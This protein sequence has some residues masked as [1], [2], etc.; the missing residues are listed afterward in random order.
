MA[1]E[2]LTEREKQVLLNLIQHYISTADPVG[3][4][5]IANKFRMGLSPATIRNTLQDLEELGLVNQPHTSAGRIP[6]DSGYRVYVNYLLKPELLTQQEKDAIKGSILKEGRGVNEI[7]GQTCKVL[8]EI[9]HQLGVSIS[10]RFDAGILKRLQLIPVAEGRI[11]IVVVVESGLA[12][13]VIIELEAT[14]P[15]SSLIEV[16][17]VLNERL[18]GLTLGEI[19][20]SISE[21]MA[22]ISGQGRLVKMIVDSKD[23]IWT[24][25]RSDEV[26]LSGAENLVA[27]PEFADIHRIS[28]LMK[29]L[30]NSSAM[31]GFFDSLEDEGLIITIGKENKLAEILNCSLVSATYKVG[32][33]SGSIGIIGP[34]RMEYNKLVSVVKYTARMIT[35]VLSRT[36]SQ[37]E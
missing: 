25:Q 14:M 35:E 29:L 19:R 4:R 18:S 30:E 22:D 8:G 21:R 5:V 26:F 36:E 33:I 23:R 16:E 11:M 10:P 28:D 7:L 1:F 27:Q 12:R 32:K 15:D 31:S 2:N 34:T 24:D 20:N 3:S 37:E 17:A 13:S 9:T 6:T